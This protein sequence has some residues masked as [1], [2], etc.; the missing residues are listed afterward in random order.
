[1]TMRLYHLLAISFVFLFSMSLDVKG[2]GNISKVTIKLMETTDVHGNFFSYDFINDREQ[3]SGLPQILTYVK[4]QRDSLGKENCLL[5][6]AGDIL[7]GQPCV[8]YS[9]F[10]D[11]AEIHLA[12]DM[13]NFIQYDAGCFGNH[14]IEAGH[15]VFDRWVRDCR[16]PVLGANILSITDNTPYALPY[17]MFERQGIKIAVLGM[18]TPAIPMWLPESLWS[19]LSFEDMVVS[20]RKWVSYI[21]E[22]EKPDILIGLFHT[23]LKG[24]NLNGFNENAAEE[25]ALTVPGFDVIFFGHDHRKYCKE[26]KNR[27]SGKKVWLLNAGSGAAGVA[28]ATLT[29]TLREKALVDKKIKGSLT[30]MNDY[31][32][33]SIFTAYYASRRKEVQ[34]FV[35][36]KIGSLA[37]EIHALDYFFGKSTLADLLHQIQFSQMEADISLITPLTYNEIIN[38]GDIYVRD[39]FKLYR[40]ENRINIFELTGKEVLGVLEKSYGMWTNTMKSSSDHALAIKNKDDKKASLTVPT[41]LLLS[42]AGISYEVDLTHSDGEKVKILRM[43]DGSAFDLDRTYRVA[44][45]SY[46]GS[47]GGGLLT[48]GAG[49]RLEDLPSRIVR[50]SDKDLR[51]YIIDYFRNHVSPIRISSV[52]DWK[53]VPEHFVGEALKRDYDLLS[54][55]N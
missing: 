38:A 37:E 49:I 12:S 46:I 2:D 14:D 26:V 47:G 28:E 53:F 35:S 34:C 45:N 40:Y 20:A 55:T 13:M 33:D 9:N 15:P 22:K 5:F 7:Q 43:K 52:S 32:P 54:H 16:F 31:C 50:T 10:I 44:V 6:D 18:I 8:Y 11:T 29:C 42:A 19:G 25:I 3:N 41:Y 21:Q 17:Q 39:I 4:S 48:E 1:M 24:G 23:G 30:Q 36:E 27:I 51:Y